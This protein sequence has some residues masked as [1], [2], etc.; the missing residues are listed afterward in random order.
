MEGR[1]SLT[2]SMV[3]LEEKF[4]TFY[5]NVQSVFVVNVAD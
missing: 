3:A 1:S 2:Y 4:A 5:V